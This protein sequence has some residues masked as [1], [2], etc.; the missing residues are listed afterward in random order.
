MLD[1]TGKLCYDHISHL[2]VETAGFLLQLIQR[3]LLDRIGPCGADAGRPRPSAEPCTT[4]EPFLLLKI[5]SLS[6][7]IKISLHIILVF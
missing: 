2:P 6:K 4:T 1:V 5:V 7:V 3:E